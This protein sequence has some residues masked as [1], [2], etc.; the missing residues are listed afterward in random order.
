MTIVRH[1]TLEAVTVESDKEVMSSRINSQLQV[2]LNM[3]NLVP[4]TFY[5][6]VCGVCGT[7]GG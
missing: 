7:G 3:L 4:N 5:V 2:R 6:C 1:L